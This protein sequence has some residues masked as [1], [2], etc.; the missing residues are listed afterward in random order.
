MRNLDY[1]LVQYH[2]D[3]Y[4][5]SSGEGADD[6]VYY[7]VILPG[8]Y[9]SSGNMSSREKLD[10]V[11]TVFQ[12]VNQVDTELVKINTLGLVNDN[13]TI[14]FISPDPEYVSDYPESGHIINNCADP[15]IVDLVDGGTCT[16]IPVTLHHPDIDNVTGGRG[17][18][19]LLL[20]DC[21]APLA[22]LGMIRGYS[23]IPKFRLA[24]STGTSMDNYLPYISGVFRG[25]EFMNNKF[26]L[27]ESRLDYEGKKTLNYQIGHIYYQKIPDNDR[28]RGNYGYR[29]YLYLGTL[30]DILLE[31]YSNGF[32]AY[33]FSPRCKCTESIPYITREKRV[34]LFLRINKIYK[35]YSIEELVSMFLFR[36]HYINEL[37]ISIRGEKLINSGQSVDLPTNLVDDMQKLAHQNIKLTS[38]KLTFTPT[39]YSKS[40]NTKP[41]GEEGFP[42]ISLG[43]RYMTKEQKR[44]AI[45]KLQVYTTPEMKDKI[46]AQFPKCTLSNEVSRLI[47]LLY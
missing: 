45:Q 28:V 24:I 2:L 35:S 29:K 41:L 15:M 1:S 43:L 17:I 47:S 12:N 18:I 42:Y 10:L 27:E 38:R 8:L 3:I 7:G 36:N 9:G 6:V 33:S 22:Q 4:Y 44:L 40:E 26:P 16:L 21:V 34:H 46:Q 19:F 23:T 30:K 37:V 11:N 32:A 5:V 20:S 31:R 39:S 13:F 14:E 25:G